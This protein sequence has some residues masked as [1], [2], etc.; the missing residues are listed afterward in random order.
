MRYLVDGYN[1]FFRLKEH[2]FPLEDARE[3]FIH[4]LSTSLKEIK[5]KA[6]LVFDSGTETILD[7][8]TKK[9][10]GDIEVIY[11]PRGMSADDYLIELIEIQKHPGTVTVVSSDNGVIARS[12]S[13]RARTMSVEQFVSFIKRKQKKNFS[14][15]EKNISDSTSNLKRLEEAFERRLKNPPEDDPTL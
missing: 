2:I 15:E 7:I 5:M 6:S 13:L 9:H 12:V 11:T 4:E 10:L 8:A 1:F 3:S 14:T